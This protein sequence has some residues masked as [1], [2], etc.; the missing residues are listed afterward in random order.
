MCGDLQEPQRK[1]SQHSLVDDGKEF[2]AFMA[3]G[4]MVGQF[5]GLDCLF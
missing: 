5:G 3:G 1:L 4:A 2:R